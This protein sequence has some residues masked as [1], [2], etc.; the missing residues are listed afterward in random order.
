MPIIPQGLP[1]QPSSIGM[2][3]RL[4]KA[5]KNLHSVKPD[6]PRG[7]MLD[8][9]SKQ[10][11]KDFGY[12][13]PIGESLYNRRNPYG[14]QP[15]DG[16]PLAQ[17]GQGTYAVPSQ[18]PTGGSMVGYGKGVFKN[19]EAEHAFNQTTNDALRE[20][21]P[22]VGDLV[23]MGEKFAK[24]QGYPLNHTVQLPGGKTH[25]INWMREMATKHGYW[26]GR[27]MSDL[28]FNTPE[29]RQ[30]LS[31]LSPEDRAKAIEQ[32]KAQ[33]LSASQTDIQRRPASTSAAS[34]PDVS[35]PRPAAGAPRGSAALSPEPSLRSP[36]E[37]RE[38]ADSLGL[39]YYGMPD[40][41]PGGQPEET[42]SL[43]QASTALTRRPLGTA[44]IQPAPTPPATATNITPAMSTRNS[45]PAT[46]NE[47]KPMALM[48]P[49]YNNSYKNT[50]STNQKMQGPQ[51]E[52]VKPGMKPQA[53][54]AMM[55]RAPKAVAPK[56]PSYLTKPGMGGGFGGIPRP[57][58]PYPGPFPPA[59]KSIYDD[60]EEFYTRTEDRER[61]AKQEFP[62]ASPAI[63]RDFAEY[64]EKGKPQT[65]PSFQLTGGSSQP[66][67]PPPRPAPATPDRLKQPN[68]DAI[69]GD[70]TVYPDP[71]FVPGAPFTPEPR[72]TLAPPL[73]G[74]KVLPGSQ[75]NNTAE[76]EIYVD[77]VGYV[78][79][80]TNQA[81]KDK[82][83]QARELRKQT[84]AMNAAGSAISQGPTTIGPDSIY[85]TD[86]M[87]AEQAKLQAEAQAREEARTNSRDYTSY[88]DQQADRAGARADRAE[89]FLKDGPANPNAPRDSR[90][91]QGIYS[92]LGDQDAANFNAMSAA[93]AAKTAAKEQQVED[94]YGKQ[95][96]TQ[97]ALGTSRD[98]D[99]DYANYVA[100]YEQNVGDGQ[101]MSPEEY[102]VYRGQETQ[103]DLRELQRQY[104]Y[105]QQSDGTP[106][107]Q[108]EFF[109]AMAGQMSP[110]VKAQIGRN[111]PGIDL[112]GT[113]R[114]PLSTGGESPDEMSSLIAAG[115]KATQDAL[116]GN[117][118]AGIIGSREQAKQDRAAALQTLQNSDRN[119]MARAREY[120]INNQFVPGVGIVANPQGAANYYNNLQNNRRENAIME[121][122]M[123]QGYDM[124]M[125]PGGVSLRA[126]D[127]PDPAN[128]PKGEG[129]VILTDTNAQN[130]RNAQQL[131]NDFFTSNPDMPFAEKL[132][133]AKEQLGPAVQGM[134][135]QYN[136][137]ASMY[138]LPPTTA[139]ALIGSLVMPKPEGSGQNRG[140]D[141]EPGAFD[142]ADASVISKAQQ[143]V[144]DSGEEMTAENVRKT[145]ERAGQSFV[146]PTTSNFSQVLTDIPA[147]TL[148][149]V[150]MALAKRGY[151]FNASE[152]LNG[153]NK[154]DL[155]GPQ[156]RAIIAFFD[157]HGPSLEGWDAARWEKLKEPGPKIP[158]FYPPI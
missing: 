10:G 152:I 158:P 12:N 151:S 29:G 44:S 117:P 47:S 100:N 84:N 95:E 147:A 112:S 148:E 49:N 137:Q 92:P 88:L 75:Y 81:D 55:N 126:P 67:M 51:P 22:A 61:I 140:R 113:S 77:G 74:G 107:S 27:S 46:P 17:T 68:P 103:S 86:E 149:E 143:Q 124:S 62:P 122:A 128:N 96:Q 42:Q 90:A 97:A 115:K 98:S 153:L 93:Q 8:S 7:K 32:A 57:T 34:P 144:A 106:L 139:D 104:Q 15:P 111:Y 4:K 21:G 154:A 20:I 71:G 48:Q 142:N 19:H 1:K 156:G 52:R 58:S 114:M 35:P 129:A 94:F 145:A 28:L 157:T 37:Q 134:V 30:W 138:G 141:L 41:Q 82:F 133:K 66:A 87:A 40:A 99:K 120:G 25:D 78:E 31:Q 118:D 50:Q 76:S 38:R 26:D 54:G 60:F 43:E 89:S 85:Y 109:E 45:E 83:D 56:I 123:Q 2:E 18:P 80:P 24:E 127:Q 121:R 125:V 116:Y 13:S 119:L 136:A 16:T 105:Y 64:Y 150:D 69:F 3:K 146:T 59:S 72:P 91:T 155:I 65:T 9:M 102:K 63:A 70:E 11:K 23:F 131:V 130:R 73:P 39:E 108:R 6:S 53:G 36:V 101:Q 79:R 135:E 110:E 132:E 5:E 33:P 14:Y